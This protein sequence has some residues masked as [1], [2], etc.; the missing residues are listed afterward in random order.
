[1]SLDGGDL[2]RICRK[3]AGF[4]QRELARK[5]GISDTGLWRYETGRDM[6]RWDKVVWCLNVC[7]YTIEIKEIE[8]DKGD[9]DSD[10]GDRSSDVRIGG[11]DSDPE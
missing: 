10:G 9:T 8:H 6:P 5:V 11:S 4:T 1:M 7:G 3:K 2:I